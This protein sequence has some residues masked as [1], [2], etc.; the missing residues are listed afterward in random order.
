MKSLAQLEI[1]LRFQKQSD[2]FELLRQCGEMRHSW[3]ELQTHLVDHGSGPLLHPVL[4]GRDWGWGGVLAGDADSLTEPR[5]SAPK[6]PIPPG[7]QLL[8]CER[9]STGLPLAA[10]RPPVLPSSAF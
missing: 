10:L 7:L 9:H 3:K 1:E 8:L 6:H 5:L 2:L 4:A